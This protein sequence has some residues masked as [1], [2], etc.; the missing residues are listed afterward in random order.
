MNLQHQQF[1]PPWAI[2]C[3][4]IADENNPDHTLSWAYCGY[5]PEPDPAA[6]IK[7][8]LLRIVIL[9]IV[10][11]ESNQRKGYASEVIKGL[12]N[13]FNEITTNADR[14]TSPG[15][16]LMLKNGFKHI[17]SH[18]KNEPDK[19]VWKKKTEKDA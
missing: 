10:T 14:I 16:Q 13:V 15:A 8:R 4:Y 1:E 11:P 2:F 3:H 12:Q 19:Y 5:I 17:K 6:T 9:D 18:A 7:E